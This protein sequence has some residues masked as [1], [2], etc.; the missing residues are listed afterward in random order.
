MVDRWVGPSSPVKLSEEQISGF[1]SL[2]LT[3]TAE[4]STTVKGA[5]QPGRP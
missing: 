3:A 1:Y 5:G 2:I 4:I